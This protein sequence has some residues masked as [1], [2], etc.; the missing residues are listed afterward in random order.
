MTNI[1]TGRE[2]FLETE[3]T[4]KKGKVGTSLLVPWLRIS[5]PM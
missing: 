4:S 3:D 2:V 1:G 5:L